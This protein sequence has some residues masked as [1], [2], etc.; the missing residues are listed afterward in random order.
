[1][2]K[3]LE[4]HRDD[5]SAAYREFNDARDK[6]QQQSQ[7]IQDKISASLDN[8]EKM[9]NFIRASLRN[10]IELLN[11]LKL[12]SSSEHADVCR[13]IAILALKELEDAELVNKQNVRNEA[14]E[15]ISKLLATT[16]LRDQFFSEVR[17][18]VL[19]VVAEL[20]FL[21]DLCRQVIK[22]E[23]WDRG[24]LILLIGALRDWEGVPALATII[25]NPNEPLDYRHKA[26][27]SLLFI[28]GFLSQ[29]RSWAKAGL[30]SPK[31]ESFF[32]F[33]SYQGYITLPVFGVPFA[34]AY[35]LLSQPEWSEDSEIERML[36]RTLYPSSTRLHNLQRPIN[37]LSSILENKNEN[38]SLRLAAL[39]AIPRFVTSTYKDP[40]PV[41]IITKGLLSES[42]EFRRET[43]D[44]LC[45]IGHAES[46]SAFKDFALNAVAN[47][48]LRLKCIIGLGKIGTA[49]ALEALREISKNDPNDDTRTAAVK[50]ADTFDDREAWSS[51]YCFHMVAQGW[52]GVLYTSINPETK[53]RLNLKLTKGALVTNVTSGG[54]ADKAGIK[55]DDI[56][57]NFNAEDI[58]RMEDFPYIVALTPKHVSGDLKL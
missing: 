14:R 10:K 26:I 42:D 24:S 51:P 17:L 39:R 38:S 21:E 7:E 15:V 43:I 2:Q 13:Y 35:R 1:M 5:I 58:K 19:R 36:P 52:L 8:L 18:R 20:H 44:C 47:R 54:P 31:F 56:I 40:T 49:P 37:A 41:A 33:V 32:P 4:K 12:D 28:K 55:T 34:E 30:Q 22:T 48:I 23:S 50:A 29:R 3:S 53:E 9:T 16:G 27:R 46:V 11:K 6:A 45:E 57:V 25:E